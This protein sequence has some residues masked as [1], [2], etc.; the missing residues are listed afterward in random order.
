MMEQR[1]SGGTRCQQ[2]VSLPIAIPSFE[3]PESQRDPCIAGSSDG[4]LVDYRIALFSKTTY[5]SWQR[6][7]LTMR[8]SARV[9]VSDAY[10]DPSG[11]RHG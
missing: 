10:L 1:N 2:A 3:T 6:I 9:F 8:F 5:I 7:D 4:E 11:Q